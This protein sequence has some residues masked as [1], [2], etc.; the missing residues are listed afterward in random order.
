MRLIK[1]K[2]EQQITSGDSGSR[3]RGFEYPGGSGSENGE[4]SEVTL[5]I[6]PIH[7]GSEDGAVEAFSPGIR[8]LDREVIKEKL[9]S[10][11]K[12]FMVLKA[13]R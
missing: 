3:G 7:K 2:I 10:M 9:V 12:T 6:K 5:V 13:N 4:L 8:K 1:E 11:M